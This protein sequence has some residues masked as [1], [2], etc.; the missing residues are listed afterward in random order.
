MQRKNET[1]TEFVDRLLD[2][3]DT[4]ENEYVELEEE[5]DKL[6]GQ[7]AEL[8]ERYLLEK[9]FR[10]GLDDEC[11]DWLERFNALQDRYDVLVSRYSALS[12]DYERSIDRYAE[13]ELKYCKL[14]REVDGAR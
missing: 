11:D 2:Q 10:E 7:H 8:N 14:K 12:H 6:K 9:E 3:I 1:V 4:M 13:A 5:R